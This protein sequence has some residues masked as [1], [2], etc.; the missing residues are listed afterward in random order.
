MNLIKEKVE[1]IVEQ[2]LKSEGFDLIELNMS[3]KNNSFMVQVL[4]DKPKGGIIVDECVSLNRKIREILENEN[5][6]TDDCF[7]EVA[8]PGADRDIQTKKDFLRMEGREII[9]YLEESVGG[10]IEHQGVMKSVG[11]DTICIVCD[12]NE[13]VLPFKTIIKAKQII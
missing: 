3:K 9:V 13:V 7:F 8:S 6:I 5:L 10:K 2:V 1:Q 12:K 4:T 11:A